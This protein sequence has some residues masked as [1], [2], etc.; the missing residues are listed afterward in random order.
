MKWIFVTGGVLSGLGKG[1]FS[2]SVAKLLEDEDRR[3]VPVKCDGYLNV[4]PGTMNPKEHGEVYVLKDGGEVDMDFGHYERF[5]DIEAVSSWNLTSGK[6]FKT[7]IDKERDGDYL[8]ETVQ[9]VPHVTDHIKETF[10]AIGEQHDADIMVVEIGGTVG[11]IENQLYL[12]TVRQLQQEEDSLL[13]HLTLVPYLETV[14][15]QKTKPTQHSVKELRAAGLSPDMIVGRSEERLDS[16]V[17]EKIALFCD[18]DTEA[19]ISNPDIETVYRLPLV[20]DDEDVQAVI[21]EELGLAFDPH[22][23]DQWRELVSNMKNEETVSIGIC[24]KYTAM[25]DSYVSIE[26]ALKHAGAHAGVHIETEL[27]DSRSIDDTAIE[28]LADRHDGIIIPGGFGKDGVTGKIDMLTYCREHGVPTLGLCFGLQLMVVEAA[29]HCGGLSDAHT[30]EVDPETEHPVVAKM[31]EQ[32]DIEALGGTMRLGDCDARLVEGTRVKELYEADHVT[33]R[34]RHRYEVNPQYHDTIESAGLQIAGYSD[35]EG[36]AEFVEIPDH[37]FYIGTQA[38]PEFRSK[39]E[40]PH[41]LFS[42]FIDA[43]R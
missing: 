37:P 36:L 39:L 29:R 13:I 14:G 6:I 31:P 40:T 38:H 22:A 3:V 16:S 12:E 2:A 15:E 27:I 5:L 41:P 23:L 20:L 10:R 17:K 21:Q 1:V 25:D 26:E 19:V 35:E 9:M 18:V 43:C 8:G 30:T 42:G 33:E 11:D 32:K 7:V 28:T 4:D 34:H 24:G